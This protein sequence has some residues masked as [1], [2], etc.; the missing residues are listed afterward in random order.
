MT[1]YLKSH[2]TGGRW[3]LVDPA[4]GRPMCRVPIDG[5][6]IRRDSADVSADD[7]CFN[8]DKALRNRGREKKPARKFVKTDRAKYRPKNVERFDR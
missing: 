6:V 1:E 3:H 2:G 5:M 7:R 8:C 4:T